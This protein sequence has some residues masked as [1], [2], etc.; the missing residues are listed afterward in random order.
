[1]AKGGEARRGSNLGGGQMRWR[2]T[3]S[4]GPAVVVSEKRTHAGGGVG[5]QEG[6]L[7]V[8]M[9]PG[10]RGGIKFKEAKN[11]LLVA[12]S[13]SG[14]QVGRKRGGSKKKSLTAFGWPGSLGGA[15]APG[16]GLRN[17]NEGK[18]I[19]AA[20]GEQYNKVVG[21]VR[22]AF[23]HPT[24]TSARLKQRR[25]QRAAR[26]VRCGSQRRRRY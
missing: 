23:E 7:R 3:S 19:A 25:P 4:C 16:G 18:I 1:V 13:R 12:D 22:N 8:A 2:R 20:H 26:R 6:T 9:R 21:V 10:H 24:Q 5:A 17:T 14:V 15:A 11:S